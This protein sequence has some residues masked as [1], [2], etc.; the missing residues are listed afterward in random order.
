MLQPAAESPQ[1]DHD[2]RRLIA[3]LEAMAEQDV[4]KAHTC[5]ELLAKLKPH[6]RPGARPGLPA[7]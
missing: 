3:R 6:L 2:L 4:R 5:Q 1:D 7:A